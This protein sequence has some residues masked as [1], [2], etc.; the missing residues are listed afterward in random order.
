M[1]AMR[2][3]LTLEEMPSLETLASRASRCEFVSTTSKFDS[4]VIFE[5]GRRYGY[6]GRIYSHAIVVSNNLII[7]GNC[8]KGWAF[9]PQEGA[10]VIST[11]D[12]FLLQT[13]NSDRASVLSA[14]K[15]KLLRREW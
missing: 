15:Q 2:F 6:Q 3:S 9:V 13:S 7:K 12:A 11:L 14:I 5:L 10:S 4:N 1:H 8:V